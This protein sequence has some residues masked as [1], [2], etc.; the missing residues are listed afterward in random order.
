MPVLDVFWRRPRKTVPPGVRKASSQAGEGL[1]S[2][3]AG[4]A[5]HFPLGQGSRRRGGSSGFEAPT[6]KAVGGLTG[7]VFLAAA[8]KWAGV[9]GEGGI[10][11]LTCAWPSVRVVCCRWR[12]GSHFPEGGG[13]DM[14]LAF[15]GEH[16]SVREMLRRQSNLHGGLAAEGRGDRTIHGSG[17]RT[18]TVR[19][20][21]GAAERPPTTRQAAP[22]TTT[23]KPVPGHGPAAAAPK[24]RIVQRRADQVRRQGRKAEDGPHTRRR[25]YGGRTPRNVMEGLEGHRRSTYT[26]EPNSSSSAWN[27]FANDPCR[28]S[29]LHE[30][31]GTC[32]H[33]IDR[34]NRDD[35]YQLAKTTIRLRPP[36]G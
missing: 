29:T 18:R 2:S 35:F 26:A 10:A 17:A 27:T 28:T 36:S 24:R 19:I 12:Q 32:S 14:K 20:S 9:G 13:P 5:A 1:R 23:R 21:I 7:V 15:K 11:G 8:E 4:R 22:A 16:C 25:H 33:H 3:S 34:K 31:P 6:R 30:L